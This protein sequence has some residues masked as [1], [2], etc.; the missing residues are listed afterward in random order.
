MSEVAKVYEVAKIH[1]KNFPHCTEVLPLSQIEKHEAQECEFQPCRK[2]NRSLKKGTISMQAH[3]ALH[4]DE[5]IMPCQFCKSELTRKELKTS[6]TCNQIIPSNKFAITASMVANPEIIP[7]EMKSDVTCAKCLHYLRIPVQCSHSFKKYCEPCHLQQSDYKQID[8]NKGEFVSVSRLTT[9]LLDLL[10]IICPDCKEGSATIS[11]EAYYAHQL[12]HH[13]CHYCSKSLTDLQSI[14]EHYYEKCLKYPV[15]CKSCEF[16]FAREDYVYHDC[17]KHYNF[18][19]LELILLWVCMLLH[20][21]INGLFLSVTTSECSVVGG[22]LKFI[23]TQMYTPLLLFFALCMWVNAQS[24][25]LTSPF[26]YKTSGMFM[27][28]KITIRQDHI[29]YILVGN[30]LMFIFLNNV[31]IKYN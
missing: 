26:I 27:K 19:I 13:Y 15:E 18:R 5:E 9:N 30:C 24:L 14:R 23:L 1:C 12:S 8:L 21:K 20:L 31:A 25:Q 28:K 2:C 10:K 4:C 11:Y 16:V 22:F 3:L 7:T 29:Y 17:I 6:H